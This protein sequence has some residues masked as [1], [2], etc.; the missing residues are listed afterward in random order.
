MTD[1]PTIE[2]VLSTR[3]ILVENGMITPAHPLSYTFGNKEVNFW[4]TT[5]G[6]GQNLSFKD[7]GAMAAILLHS[8]KKVVAS[9]AGNHSQGVAVAC[10]KRGIDATIFM[11]DSVT[12]E[13][14][15]ATERLGD[16]FVEVLT[17]YN[18]KKIENLA[19]AIA[20]GKQYADEQGATF[21][22]PFDDKYVIAGAGTHALDLLD[23]VLIKE[24]RLR[25]DSTALT[26]A[27]EFHQIYGSNWQ[28]HYKAALEKVLGER[29]EKLR[30]Y[31]PAGGG[32]LL[33][34]MG[35][36]INHLLSNARLIGVESEKTNSFEES[37]K[38]GEPVLVTP[39]TGGKYDDGDPVAGGTAVPKFGSL[40][41]EVVN[42]FKDKVT[43]LT[44]S[45]EQMYAGTAVLVDKMA[46]WSELPSGAAL[47]A[48]MEKY[49]KE[50]YPIVVV[51][52]ENLSKNELLFLGNFNKGNTEKISALLDGNFSTINAFTARG[53]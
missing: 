24:A 44:M 27:D 45:K 8:A 18:G 12:P 47:A 22:P 46:M 10:E 50:T 29:G 20:I 37:F 6:P 7:R 14:K 33:A 40:N 48:C 36:V 1:L 2:D 15:A 26:S 4:Q 21:I 19:E 49:D 43:A 13:K 32:G 9:S 35:L 34:G 52:G 53:K 38:T 31:I 25:N 17:E 39:P 51:S 42:S 11:P 30:L 41:L 3:R 23:G 16:G 28:Q 5:F